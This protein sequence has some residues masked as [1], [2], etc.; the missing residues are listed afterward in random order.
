MG[1]HVDEIIFSKFQGNFEEK[2]DIV[3][4]NNFEIAVIV[5]KKFVKDNFKT[6]VSNYGFKKI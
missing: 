2:K 4:K 6:T 5:K 3:K 1:M